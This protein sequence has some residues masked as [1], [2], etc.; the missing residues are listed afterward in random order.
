MSNKS[1]TNSKSSQASL[2]ETTK[3]WEKNR[4]KKL[5]AL[6][7]K[8]PNNKDLEKALN[9]ISYRRKTPK[10]RVWSKTKIKVA[11]LFKRYVGRVDTAIFNNNEKISIPAH[12]TSGP[13]SKTKYVQ[14]N[15]KTMF[16]LGERVKYT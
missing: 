7:L 2:Y 12:F 5:T 4:T 9:N 8:H 1:K 11:Q 10:S 15:Q 13:H 3:R 16:S 6:A 14:P